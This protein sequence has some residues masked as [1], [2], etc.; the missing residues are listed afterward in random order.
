LYTFEIVDIFATQ[1]CICKLNRKGEPPSLAHKVAKPNYNIAKLTVAKP[2]Y[3]KTKLRNE[4]IQIITC[5]QNSTIIG[6][7][8]YC[9]VPSN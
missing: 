5:F 6:D 8:I 3:N 7:N 9:L 4:I 2:N 1:C